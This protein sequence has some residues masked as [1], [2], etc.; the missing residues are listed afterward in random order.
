[1]V[2]ACI[3]AGGAGQGSVWPG[4]AKLGGS[5]HSRRGRAGQGWAGQ[6][7]AGA[8]GRGVARHGMAWRG[9]HG[10]SPRFEQ[11]GR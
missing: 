6:G 4:A 11:E 9:R 3:L 2:R 1:M 10:L 7:I 5:R 8:A